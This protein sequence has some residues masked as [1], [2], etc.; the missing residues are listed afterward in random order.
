MLWDSSGTLDFATLQGNNQAVE[1]GVRGPDPVACH[2]VSYV[3]MNNA[4]TARYQTT[5]YPSL[6]SKTWCLEREVSNRQES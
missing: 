1:V 3:S 6:G 2:Q 5:N 4:G